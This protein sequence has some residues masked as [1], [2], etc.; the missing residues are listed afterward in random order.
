MLK[1][2]SINK[3]SKFFFAQLEFMKEEKC[4]PVCT[5]FYQ[6]EDPVSSQKLAILKNGMGLN[7]HHHWIVG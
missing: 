4:V 7:Y 1:S 6:G 5:K 3:K 2:E